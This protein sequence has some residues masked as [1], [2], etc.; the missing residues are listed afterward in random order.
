MRRNLL[1]L[2]GLLLAL[3]PIAQAQDPTPVR[4]Q[5]GMDRAVLAELNYVRAHPSGFA[6]DLRL[7]R[8]QFDGRVLRNPQGFGDRMTN[9]GVEAVDE[10]I[11]FLERQAP[12]PPLSVSPPLSRAAA[13]QVRDQGPLGSIGHFS[14]TG[15]SPADRVRR[16][17][18]MRGVVAESISY[19][20]VTAEAVVRAFVVDDGVRNR[21]HRT[22]VFD[23]YLRYAGVACGPH[24]TYRAMCVVDFS[25][26][27]SAG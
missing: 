2:A 12:L 3:A 16:Y 7:Y 20:E 17:G 13:D 1:S 8:E 24:R 4:I 23:P 18:P 25:G 10:A 26:P 21:S 27:L 15:A 5:A 22:D 9:E 11:R 6:R 14:S 19:G